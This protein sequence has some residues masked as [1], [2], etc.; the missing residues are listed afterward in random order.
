MKIS[1]IA[2]MFLLAF[3]LAGCQTVQFATQA[4]DTEA[5]SFATD[6]ERAVLYIWNEP[7]YGGFAT[8]EVNGNR[9]GRVSRG[10]FFRLKLAPGYYLVESKGGQAIPFV[11]PISVEAGKQYFVHLEG[12]FTTASWNRLTLLDDVIGRAGVT[13]S[14]MILSEFPDNQLRPFAVTPTKAGRRLA[15]GVY[16]SPEFKSASLQGKKP[17]LFYRSEPY[18]IPVGQAS[19]GV[20]E[21]VLESSFDSVSVLPEWPSNNPQNAKDLILV[22]RITNFNYYHRFGTPIISYQVSVQV[23]GQG[24]IASIPLEGFALDNTWSSAI[25]SAAGQLILSLEKLPEVATRVEREASPIKA[26]SEKPEHLQD[27]E[28]RSKG[29]SIVPLVASSD[30]IPAVKK[31]Q[32]C[33]ESKAV[34]ISSNL[35]L[36]PG[37]RIRSA[38]FPWL[39]VGM[40]PSQEELQNFLGQTSIANR[41][42]QF[43]VR[44]ILFP[45][46]EHASNFGGPFFCGG[47]GM[48]AGCFGAAGGEE[49]TRFSIPV[50]DVLN[51]SMLD[52]PIAGEK[53]ENSWIVGFIIPI[54]HMAD[55]VG[56]ACSEIIK[57]LAGRI[58]SQML[59]SSHSAPDRFIK[60]SN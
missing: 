27:L 55:T 53:K 30:T 13:A 54:W 46:F 40:T 28:F 59:G 24:E 4:E 45:K 32:T 23:P 8:I 33:L 44:F 48:G 3:L 19:Q 26:R 11:L 57:E 16:F 43:G 7:P 21:R 29:I 37:S 22:P 50:W 36:V 47:S 5:K 12:D 35:R 34:S 17:L 20:F 41:F 31:M 42:E 52:T 56:D 38:A 25:I 58:E 39:E 9:I 15:V 60:E 6:T 14:K 10:T 1:N 2:L 49:V 51:N 18:E